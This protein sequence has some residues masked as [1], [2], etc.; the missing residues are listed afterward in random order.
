[1]GDATL[2]RFFSLHF[3]L[4][5]IRAGLALIHRVLLHQN[6]SG[7]PRGVDGKSDA[8]PFYPY[9]W[10]KDLRSFRIRMEVRSLLVFFS[11]NLLGHPDNYTPANGMVTPTHIV[12]E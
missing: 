12:P 6:G 3:T 5:F 4:P 1:M 2:H 10:V 11:P 8:I 9:F 7:N